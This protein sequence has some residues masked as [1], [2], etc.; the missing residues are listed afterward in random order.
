MGQARLCL[1]SSGMVGKWLMRNSRGSATPAPQFLSPEAGAS[2]CLMVEQAVLCKA[3]LLALTFNLQGELGFGS[4]K[5][6]GALDC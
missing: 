4:F 6:K 2:L 1:M 3:Y 5:M